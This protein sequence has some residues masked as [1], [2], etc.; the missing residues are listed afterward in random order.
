M[1]INKK[2]L[3]RQPVK[4]CQHQILSNCLQICSYTQQI[5]VKKT[6]V[7]DWSGRYGMLQVHPA[8]LH[9]LPQATLSQAAQK[10]IFKLF[11][12]YKGQMYPLLRNNKKKPISYLFTKYNQISHLV[13]F[14]DLEMVVQVPKHVWAGPYWYC[15]IGRGQSDWRGRFPRHVWVQ[16]VHPTQVVRRGAQGSSEGGPDQNA[17]RSIFLPEM[18]FFTVG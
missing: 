8:C 7:G 2:R 3:L 16:L 1:P 6:G 13:F 12:E 5:S 18:F 17:S 10:V 4:Y 11:T 14:M 15:E 9:T